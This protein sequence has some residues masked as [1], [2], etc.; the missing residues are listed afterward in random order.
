MQEHVFVWSVKYIPRIK[1]YV[2]DAEITMRKLRSYLKVFM[3]TPAPA[4]N[5]IINSKC[6]SK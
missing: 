6:I 2:R 3:W 1:L 5:V 4:F